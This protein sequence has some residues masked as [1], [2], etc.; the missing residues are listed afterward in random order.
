MTEAEKE[1]AVAAIKFEQKVMEEQS[2]QKVSQIQGK[3]SLLL[4]YNRGFKIF[5]FFFCIPNIFY[6]YIFQFFFLIQ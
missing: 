3:V 1:A 5:Y 6:M 2:K 4:W